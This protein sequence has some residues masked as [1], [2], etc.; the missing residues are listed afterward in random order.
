MLAWQY[1][2][3]DNANMNNGTKGDDKTES[4]LIARLVVLIPTHSV[5][6]YVSVSGG[7][8]VQSRTF[9]QKQ[10][11]IRNVLTGRNLHKN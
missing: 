7:D 3:N 11:G 1:V 10:S 8:K 9:A 2:H 6:R 4:P 5:G